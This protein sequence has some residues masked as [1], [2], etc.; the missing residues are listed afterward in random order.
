[1][2]RAGF[3]IPGDIGLPTGGYAYDRE[4]LKRLA[5][6]GVEVTHIALAGT[7][8]APSAADLE[9]SAR[10]IAAA[11]SDAV[12]L[13]D[14]LAYGVFPPA[15]VRQLDRPV[16]ALCH[17]PLGYE[18]G[19]SEARMRDLVAAER[20]ALGAARHVIV[21]S[22][23]TAR[24]LSSEFAVPSS[25]I[26]VAEPGTRRVE[27]AHGTGEPPRLIAVGSVVPRKGYLVLIEAL[28][29]LADLDW[30]ID[31]VG[32]LRDET[33]TA[34]VRGAIAASPV[35]DR[36]ALVGALGEAEL[37]A[38]YAAA[39]LFVMS[40]LYEGYGMVLSE[41]MAFGLPIVTTTGGAAAETVP[42]GA[43]IKVP[44][45]DAEAL[46]G[47]LRDVL[48]SEPL[49]Q[50]LAARSWEAGRTLQGWDDTARRIAA[51]LKEVSR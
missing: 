3:V 32:A 34:A 6:H 12:L 13:I 40:S 21:T 18:T 16:V 41:A 29:A 4:V 49:R 2:T 28:S 51:V 50:S 7:F 25:K 48:S 35:A 45:G 46:A 5:A 44:P 17:H 23:T 22:Q 8:P 39:D 26:T 14:G 15:L 37:D 33:E 9:E 43:A 36:I 1:M 11:P 27:R 10:R 31:I 38:R 47:A 20:L 24:L 19:L 30:Q 42:D